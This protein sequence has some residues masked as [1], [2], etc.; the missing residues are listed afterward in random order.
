M[1]TSQFP[2]LISAVTS[3][4]CAGSAHFHF[5]YL[6]K[7]ISSTPYS[8][9]KYTSINIYSFIYFFFSFRLDFDLISAAY[10]FDSDGPGSENSETRFPVGSGQ[11]REMDCRVIS[12]NDRLLMNR[13]VR[14][15]AAVAAASAFQ[16]PRSFHLFITRVSFYLF[17]Y[18]QLWQESQVKSSLRRCS[19]KGDLMGATLIKVHW[20]PPLSD[21]WHTW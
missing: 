10:W 2:L 21:Q 7:R 19:I 4:I 11:F 9:Y 14:K 20:S 5:K 16:S 8:I 6:N 17:I 12:R 15:M 18:I 1:A 13:P 3:I